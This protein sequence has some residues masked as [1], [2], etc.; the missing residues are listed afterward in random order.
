MM[1]R[2]VDILMVV[3]LPLLMAYSLIGETFHEAAGTAML[4]LF[5]MH[6]ISHRKWWK[7]IP[8]GKYTSYRTFITVLDLALLALLILQP[9]SGIAMSHHL[10]TF[11]HLE[12]VSAAARAIHL[13]LAYWSLVLMS[14]HLG[15]HLDLFLKKEKMRSRPGTIAAGLISAYGI[16]AF[17]KRGLPG[18]MFLKTRFAFFDF[19]EPI[20]FFM[21]DYLAIMALFAAAGYCIKLKLRG[22]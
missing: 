14:L 16:Y 10:Y 21:I 8:K 9:L 22:K 17:I 12:G 4:V 19:G 18:Y 3:L 20:I 5:I 7:A 2:T 13:A 6:L 15:L 11:I 1:K